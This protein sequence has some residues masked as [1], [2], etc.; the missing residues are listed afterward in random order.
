MNNCP[1]L[2]D[3]VF[4]DEGCAPSFSA[5]GSTVYICPAM[6]DGSLP[7][8]SDMTAVELPADYDS[9]LYLSEK[10]PSENSGWNTEGYTQPFEM[11]ITPE[12]KEKQHKLFDRLWGTAGLTRKRIVRERKLYNWFRRKLKNPIRKHIP[13]Y[14]KS[15]H[16]S[17]INVL[18]HSI[19]VANNKEAS[20][21]K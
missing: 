18:P 14:K 3:H 16:R 6:P 8:L 7:K 15:F 19:F 13:L 10:E 5:L 1:T 11:T 17:V 2:P 12:Y 4:Q 20:K 21:E 9:N